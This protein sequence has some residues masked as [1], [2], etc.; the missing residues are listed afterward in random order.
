[1]A[2][3][4]LIPLRGRGSELETFTKKVF[5]VAAIILLFIALWHVRR[6]LIILAIAAALA[7]GIAPAV[8]RVQ[9]L[10]RHHTGSKV[11]R[12]TAVLLVYLPFVA[13]AVT[14]LAL[15]LPQ[16]LAQSKELSTDLPQM[17]NDRFLEPASKYVPPDQLERFVKA[18]RERM[19][20]E[21]YIRGIVTTV[22]AI[23]A[24][25]FLIVYMLID[26]ERLKNL[27]LLLYPAKERAAKRNLIRRVSRR[28]SSWLSG[29]LILASIIGGATLIALLLF[30]IP[31]A[32]PLALIAGVGEMIP[33][34]GPIIGAVPAL[35]VAAFQSPWQFWAVLIFAIA[36]QQIE[37]Y[38]IVPR[39][40]GS[41]VHI[42]PLAV[43]VAFMCGATLLGVIGAIMAIPA[44][45]IL[46]VV[47]EESFVT[48]RERRQNTDRP[49]TLAKTEE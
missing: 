18:M 29:Q 10:I 4:P 13:F 28:M 45:A 24:I 14:F 40:M 48:K 43:F 12:G 6:I 46:Q 8:R 42:S 3:N 22:S 2:E 25:L 49:G 35:M 9:I 34:L 32:F 31:Y 33:L 15:T 36:V 26:A 23:V 27:F 20:V 21:T 44:A 16:L 38:L 30:R 5:I 11:A 17:L 19:H 39:V 41:K 1:V 7:A 37:N 47:F